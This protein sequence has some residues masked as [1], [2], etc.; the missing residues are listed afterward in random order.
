MPNVCGLRNDE[1]DDIRSQR[2]SKDSEHKASACQHAK[3]AGYNQ[4]YEA[5]EQAFRRFVDVQH[6]TTWP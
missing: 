1:P 6:E 4:D 3:Q 5:C 2:T